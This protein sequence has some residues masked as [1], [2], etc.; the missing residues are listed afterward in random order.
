MGVHIKQARA[1]CACVGGGWAAAGSVEWRVW[2]EM[3]AVSL[4]GLGGVVGGG[5]VVWGA[6]SW[7]CA[8]RM[9]V[10]HGWAVCAC[11]CG[12]AGRRV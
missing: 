8:V 4:G 11:G 12:A 10:E 9:G 3:M 7:A 1:A 5:V 6:V 2:C